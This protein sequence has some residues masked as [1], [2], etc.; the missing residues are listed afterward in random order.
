MFTL[1]DG[2]TF[3]SLNDASPRS[4][5][6]MAERLPKE[7]GVDGISWAPYGVGV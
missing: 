7:V 5:T 6:K 1:E 4:Q 3:S 2:T